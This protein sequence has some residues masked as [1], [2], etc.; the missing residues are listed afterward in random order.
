MIKNVKILL[1]EDRKE[2]YEELKG[3]D[4]LT[5]ATILYWGP[6]ETN[7]L[8]NENEIIE[9]TKNEL[10]SVYFKNKDYPSCIWVV[11]LDYELN[12]SPKI[13][14][15]YRK[16]VIEAIS[17]NDMVYLIPYTEYDPE[18]CSFFY[19]EIRDRQISDKATKFYL[20]YRLLLLHMGDPYKN[21]KIVFKRHI[22]KELKP[23]AERKINNEKW[24]H[25]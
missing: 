22:N 11:L 5:E 6:S 16:G 18:G 9:R 13:S 7:N 15:A 8:D 3:C 20:F 2:Y 17:K 12:Q 24:I 10:N 4:N 25:S 1:I 19:D 21:Y 14:S 23:I